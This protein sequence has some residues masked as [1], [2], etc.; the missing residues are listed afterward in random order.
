MDGSKKPFQV[1]RLD[2]SESKPKPASGKGI[3][4]T[5]LDDMFDICFVQDGDKQLLVVAAFEA[6]LFAY[7]IK[8]RKLEWKVDG[9]VDG[10]EQ[11]LDA[12][13][14]TTDES[15]HLLVADSGNECIQMFSAS[16]GQYLGFLMKGVEIIGDP[17]RVHWSTETS[18]VLA[19]CSLQDTFSWHLQF[20]NIQHL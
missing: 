17:I 7:N 2:L 13:G 19:A 3:I 1:C 4:H 16:D 18:S 10:M 14:V 12:D 5:Q 6:G 20:I 9:K 8:R 15:G 11:V